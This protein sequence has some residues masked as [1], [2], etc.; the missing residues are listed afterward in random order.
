MTRIRGDEDDDENPYAAPQAE[1]NVDDAGSDESR[2]DRARRIVRVPA[3]GLI[4]VGSVGLAI[5]MV[6]LGVV[7]VPGIVDRRGPEWFVDLA[8]PMAFCACKLV[9]IV[10]GFQMLWLQSRSFAIAASLLAIVNFGWFCC[11]IGLPVGVWSLA[12]LSN[13]GV[14][15]A[16]EFRKSR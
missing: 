16:F 5:S 12:V 4:F 11:V 10:G 3:L 14:I 2:I 7:F 15:R 1:L 9:I 6:S 13:S 8:I